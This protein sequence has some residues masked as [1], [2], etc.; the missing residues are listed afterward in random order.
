MTP[1]V[2]RQAAKS[3]GPLFGPFYLVYLLVDDRKS[4]KYLPK[5]LSS[6]RPHRSLLGEAKPWIPFEAANWL[7]LYL[8]RNMRVFE[9]GSGGSTIFLSERA[10]H[11]FSVEHDQKWHA[12]VSKALAERGITNCSYQLHEPKPLP[13]NFSTLDASQTSRFIYDDYYPG[14][15][16]DEYVRAIDV[17]PDHTF[18][19][20][21][22]DGRARTEC[23]QHAIPKIK[24][25]GYLMLDNSNNA[26]TVEIIRKMQSY[27]HTEFRGIAPGWPPA[28]WSNTIWQIS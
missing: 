14:T 6:F 11:I 16:L 4:W 27:P 8:R 23:I 5:W 3:L 1:L 28:R 21:L 10:G 9:W 12:L 22:V 20:V 2:K 15:T 24:P 19:L 17:H 13:G 25:A 26:D 18:D 7:Q